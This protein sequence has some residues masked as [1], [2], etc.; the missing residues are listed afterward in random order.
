MKPMNQTNQTNQTKNNILVQDKVMFEDEVYVVVEVKG[1]ALHVKRP[2]FPF[3]S[4]LV[5]AD[6]VKLV[7][8]VETNKV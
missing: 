3:D 4:F 7:M 1:N 2:V 6:E 5:A 8:Q